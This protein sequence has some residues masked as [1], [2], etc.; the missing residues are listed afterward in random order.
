M[1]FTLNPYL[2]IDR[3]VPQVKCC[4]QAQYT[5]D[6]GEHVSENVCSEDFTVGVKVS[7][8]AQAGPAIFL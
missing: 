1:S 8:I 2:I 4:V 3:S 5:D 7:N 6:C